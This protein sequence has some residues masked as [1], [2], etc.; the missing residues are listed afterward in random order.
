MDT[1]HS[2]GLLWASDAPDAETSTWHSTPHS[3]DTDIRAAGGIRTRIP[4]K[5][6]AA[7][8]RL[9]PRV[10]W[11]WPVC[12]FVN[13]Y[14]I[15]EWIRA[16]NLQPRNLVAIFT[17]LSRLT[18]L[19]NSHS[20]VNRNNEV[21]VMVMVIIT[22][23]FSYLDP[24]HKLSIKLI[25]TRPKT[26]RQYFFHTVWLGIHTIA[27]LYAVKCGLADSSLLYYIFVLYTGT[28]VST[29]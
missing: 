9:R 8:A 20:K 7:D 1:P 2:V 18:V 17:T 28:Y 14:L 27:G 13:R 15:P 10:H 25:N 29:C 26:T 12:T 11:D 16:P 6:A 23:L 5:W 19:T 21:V 24:V 3:K 4:S 22:S